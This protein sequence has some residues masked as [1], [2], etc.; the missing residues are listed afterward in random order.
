MQQR[1]I[2]ASLIFAGA[3]LCLQAQQPTSQQPQTTQ[4]TMR[5]NQNPNAPPDRMGNPGAV[6]DTQSTMP[7]QTGQTAQTRNDDRTFVKD[8]AVGGMTEVE[9]GK[10]AAEKG[11]SEGVKQFGQKMVADHSKANDELKQVASAQSIT[12]PDS[13]DAKHKARVDKMSKLSGEEFD[14]AYIKDQLKDHQ[15]DVKEFEREANSGSIP[16]VKDFASKTLPT[17]KE[18]LSMVKDLDKGKK[19]TSADR[20]TT[21]PQQ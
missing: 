12:I 11:S 2:I 5:P 20:S 21:R 17:L 6:P 4:P 1:T 10:L 3:A 19:S 13:L 7:G 9:L 14:R 16:A 18:H 8:A 15:Q